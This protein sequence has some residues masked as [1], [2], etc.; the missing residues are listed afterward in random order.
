[1]Q[2]EFT[3]SFIFSVFSFFGGMLFQDSRI[4][5]SNIRE[6]AKEIDEKVLEPLIILLKKSKDCT[7]SDN[8]TVLEK[9]RAISVLDEKCFV[10]FL[11]NSGVFKLEDEDIRVVYKKDKIFNRHAI[12]IAQYLKDYLVEVN[13]L[14]EIIEN[15]RAED[16]PSNFEQK[17]RK[18][19][20]DEFGNDCLDTGDRREEFVFVLFAVSVC[21]SKNSYKNGRVCIID[22]IGRRFQDLQ[23]IVKDDQNAY[24]L[25]LKVVG[26]QKNISFIHSN[27]LKEIES[28]QEDWQ[29]K[30]II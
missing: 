15:L 28:L 18:L 16:I 4:K 8:Y 23:N 9:N 21:N 26:I 24:E 30:L 11:I 25:L 19:I 7:E 22:I 3:V 2:I 1:M 27:V 5:K 12:K 6:K 29:N 13:S 14:K 17:V 10:D 20:K